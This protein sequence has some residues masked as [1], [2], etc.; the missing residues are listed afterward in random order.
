M[1][2]SFQ[3]PRVLSPEQTKTRWKY[4]RDNYTKAR[5]KIKNYIPSGSAA[6]AATVKKSNFRF[7]DLMMFLNDV[8][9]TRQT[10]SSL[11]DD[12]TEIYGTLEQHEDNIA[13]SESDLCKPQV[14]MY[15]GKLL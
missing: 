13:T 4:L 11:T 15:P 7:Y 1:G 12:V 5:K 2:R 10:V 9:E 14:A 8:L 6:K 3:H